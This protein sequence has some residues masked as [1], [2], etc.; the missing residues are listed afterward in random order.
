MSVPAAF[1]IASGSANG[2]ADATLEVTVMLA[3]TTAIE[4]QSVLLNIDISPF[5]FAYGSHDARKL[6]RHREY[7]ARCLPTSQRRRLRWRHQIS[8]RLPNPPKHRYGPRKGFD[9]EV[10]AA[11]LVRNRTPPSI[12]NFDAHRFRL[13]GRSPSGFRFV[14]PRGRRRQARKARRGTE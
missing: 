6:R 2:K 10:E 7:A 4:R 1:L 11:Q 8:N 3:A 14:P 9:R 5:F 12:R 13:F